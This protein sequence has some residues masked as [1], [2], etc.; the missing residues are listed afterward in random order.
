MTWSHSVSLFALGA[1][2]LAL[3]RMRWDSAVYGLTLHRCCRHDCGH[4][5]DCVHAFAFVYSLVHQQAEPCL[6]LARYPSRCW[7]T[8]RKKIRLPSVVC[9]IYSKLGGVVSD[10]TR[11]NAWTSNMPASPTFRRLLSQSFIVD[12]ILCP[13]DMPRLCP[14]STKYQYWPRCRRRGLYLCLSSS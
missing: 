11:H 9:G 12:N 4:D 3:V 5:H 1:C 14:L 6:Y 10:C 2:I 8:L 13:L 7:K